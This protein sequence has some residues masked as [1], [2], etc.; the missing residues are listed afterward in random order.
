M[1]SEYF[2]LVNGL[3]WQSKTKSEITLKSILNT[4]LLHT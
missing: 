3:T 4:Q 1:F 2:V